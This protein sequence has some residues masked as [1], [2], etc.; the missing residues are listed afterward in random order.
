MKELT[1]DIFRDEVAFFEFVKDTADDWQKKLLRCKK[2]RI[3]IRCA[4]QIGKTTT[5]A[6][7]ALFKALMFPKQEILLLAAYQRQSSHVFD[8]VCTFIQENQ[9]IKAQVTQGPSAKK[10]TFANGSIIHCFPTG[11][12]GK[13]VVGFSPNLIIFDESAFIKDEAFDNIEP[14]LQATNGTMILVGTPYTPQGY[15]FQKCIH[16]NDFY[17]FHVPFTKCPR[18][19]T[20]TKI[21]SIEEMRKSGEISEF[22]YQTQYMAEFYDDVENLITEKQA[23]GCIIEIDENQAVDGTKDYIMSVDFARFGSD[24]TVYMIAERNLNK[25]SVFSILATKKMPLTDAIGRIK[26]LY[27]IW[28]P[29]QIFIDATQLGAGANDVLVEE[30]FPIIP[31]TFTSKEKSELYKNLIWCLDNKKIGYP[32]NEKLISQMLNMKKKFDANANLQIITPAKHRD[33]HADA[34]ALICKGW[35]YQSDTGDDFFVKAF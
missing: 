13:S 16:S 18:I 26:D 32:M 23:R 28:R 19:Y 14:S 34:L 8:M 25:I 2:D 22:Y 10:V 6:V 7:I 31:V 17:N 5:V 20:P 9:F 29:S 33:D 12:A 15:Y 3:T 24:E 21:K 1:E 27:K 11:D 35:N 30:G 4:R